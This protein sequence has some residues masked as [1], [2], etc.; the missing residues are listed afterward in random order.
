MRAC[1][2]ARMRNEN[3]L[4]IVV[5]VVVDFVV[6]VVLVD[7]VVVVVV[8]VVMLRIV[9]GMTLRFSPSPFT[10]CIYA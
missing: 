3:V 2:W 5:V 8:V 1:A 7:I 9:V 4:R 6:V 10:P